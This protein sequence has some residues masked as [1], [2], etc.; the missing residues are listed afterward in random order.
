MAT[1]PP[2]CKQFNRHTA[3]MF[4]RS[5]RLVWFQ[6]L[7]VLAAGLAGNA[8]A[9]P[10]PYSADAATLHL[11]HL[12]ETAPPCVDSAAGGTNLTALVNGA[13]LG[14]ANSAFAGFGTCL[15]TVDGGQSNPTQKDAALSVRPLLNGTGDDVLLTL[16]DPVTGA[17][18]FEALVRMDFDPAVSLTAR[19]SPMQIISGDGD[20]TLDRVFQ[21]RLIPAGI[22]SGASDTNVTRMEFINLRQGTGIQSLGFLLPTNGV[23]AIASNQWY[24]VAVTYNGN[25][26]TAS[27]L[28]CYWTRA[29]AAV[30]A[31]NIIGAATMSNDLSVASCDFVLGNE[32]RATGGSTGNFI[33]LIDEVRISRVARAADQM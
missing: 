14:P 3:M 7:A 1:K 4:S 26:N 27:N 6:L 16:A 30:P 29:D 20:G 31:A 15:S 28:L 8:L 9:T 2:I 5:R 32:G 12:D 18:T 33:G 13:T 25:E 21:W 24:H 11:W 17:F 22:V 10:A 19:G 23:N